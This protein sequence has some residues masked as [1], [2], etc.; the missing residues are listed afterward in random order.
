MN[1]ESKTY[2]PSIDDIKVAA[3]TIKKVSAVTP[4]MPNVRLSKAF[5]SNINFCYIAIRRC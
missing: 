4:L 2:F 1:K 3:D 5:N